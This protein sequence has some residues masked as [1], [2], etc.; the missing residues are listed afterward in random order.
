MDGS[1]DHARPCAM[2]AE[3]TLNTQIEHLQSNYNIPL[4]DSTV[5]GYDVGMT[6]DG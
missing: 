3:A 6:G 1:N 5:S 2:D 4:D